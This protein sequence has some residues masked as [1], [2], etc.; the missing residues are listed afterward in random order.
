MDKALDIVATI[1]VLAV[2]IVFMT[3]L[4]NLFVGTWEPVTG[5]EPLVRFFEDGSWRMEYAP[6][7]NG[8]IPMQICQ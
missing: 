3:L 8:C 6:Y 2:W 4:L 7:W 5:V 1:F